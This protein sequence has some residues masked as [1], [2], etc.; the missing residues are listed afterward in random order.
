MKVSRIKKILK[1]LHSRE[2]DKFYGQ[3]LVFCISQKILGR[4]ILKGLESD[5][6]AFHD[7]CLVSIIERLK[8]HLQIFIGILSIF[9]TSTV[10]THRPV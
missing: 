1:S 6:P 8:L 5:V 4:K 3:I 2:R 7:S 9:N 10:L